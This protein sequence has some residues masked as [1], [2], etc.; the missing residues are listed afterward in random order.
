MFPLERAEVDEDDR[1]EGFIEDGCDA[2][3]GAGGIRLGFGGTVGFIILAG[4]G[5]R[6]GGV[7]A[8]ALL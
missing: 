1:G 6:G 7:F 5:G 8:R 4:F 2:V 3:W